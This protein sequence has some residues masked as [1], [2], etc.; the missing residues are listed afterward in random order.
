MLCSLHHKPHEL[1]AQN[2]LNLVSLTVR[3]GTLTMPAK[4]GLRISTNLF[5]GDGDSDGVDRG[6]NQ[7]ALLLVAAD[8]HRSQDKLT[9]TPAEFRGQSTPVEY[10]IH[11][12]Y[13]SFG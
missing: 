4:T 12:M 11:D 7:N 13:N 3:Y 10:M 8:H 1:L 5:D 9:T 6:L 2:L